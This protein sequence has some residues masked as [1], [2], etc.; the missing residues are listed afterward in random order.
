MTS[1]GRGPSRVLRR[2]PLVNPR[3]C[4]SC[5][6]KFHLPR[7]GQDPTAC[8]NRHPKAPDTVP[9]SSSFRQDSRG[10]TLG[11]GRIDSLL[12]AIGPTPAPSGLGRG[13]LGRR[14]GWAGPM[15]ALHER[16]RVRPCWAVQRRQPRSALRPLCRPVRR[17]SGLGFRADTA[18]TTRTATARS[19][20]GDRRPIRAS[21]RRPTGHGLQGFSLLTPPTAKTALAHPDVAA[22][23]RPPPAAPSSRSRL[24]GFSPPPWR[25]A[26]CPLTGTTTAAPHGREDLDRWFSA[27][28]LGA[29]GSPTHRVL[30]RRGSVLLPA[31]CYGWRRAV[32]RVVLTTTVLG[33]G[34]YN[35]GQTNKPRMLPAGLIVEAALGRAELNRNHEPRPCGASTSSILFRPCAPAVPGTLQRLWRRR[36]WSC[37]ADGLGLCPKDPYDK[38]PPQKFG[39]GR[40]PWPPDRRP[41][42]TN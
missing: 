14:G 2:R 23:A 22:S 42:V 40:A 38:T 17:P 33:G 37:P 36:T 27:F 1:S 32:T 19:G 13:R 15:E 41:L 30:C 21:W 12:P 34:R 18:V 25:R 10:S 3:R 35:P 11:V 7:P 31:R 5:R 29:R 26:W 28:R 8:P 24:P 39:G 6:T 16:G 20:L 4:C 9:R